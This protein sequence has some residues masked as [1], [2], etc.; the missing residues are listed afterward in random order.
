MLL[1]EGLLAGEAGGVRPRG[2]LLIVGNRA[3]ATGFFVDIDL[4]GG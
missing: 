2:G 3:A 4:M 1:F